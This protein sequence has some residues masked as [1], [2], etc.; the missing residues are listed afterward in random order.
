MIKQYASSYERN[1]EPIAAVLGERLPSSG[2][3]L[4]VG[5]GTGQHAAFMAAAF[6][7]LKWQPTDLAEALPS[8]A[9]WRED[10]A[11]TNLHPPLALDLLGSEVWPVQHADALLCINTIHIVAMAGARALFAGA[12]R[13]LSAG[14]VLIT[15][16]PYRFTDQPLAPSNEDFDV[17]LKA[18]D[19]ASGIRD[20]EALD[21][22]ATQAGLRFIERRAMPA[23]NHMLLWRRD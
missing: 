2:L 10:S 8:I 16:G 19:P 12:G 6:P 18:R 5:S 1:R 4:E 11:A 21:E 22:L 20:F 7:A 14:G 13:V 15:Y 3:V 9:A 17:W 23:N